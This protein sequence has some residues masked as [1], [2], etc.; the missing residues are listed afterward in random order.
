MIVLSVPGLVEK[1]RGLRL[2]QHEANHTDGSADVALTEIMHLIDMSAGIASDGW[3][4]EAARLFAIDAAVMVVRRY[5]NLLTESDRQAVMARLHEARR[6]V[7]AGRDAELE[8]IQSTLESHLATAE[9]GIV[10]QIWLVC[11]DALL[12][13]PFRA[14][15]IVARTAL[16]TQAAGWPDIAKQLRERLIARLDEGSLL[17]EPASTLFLIA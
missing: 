2:L 9:P 5:S 14:A 11:I 13:S 12:P 7:V 8:F 6:L 17:A 4:S 1:T 10:R 15:L 3:H 16:L